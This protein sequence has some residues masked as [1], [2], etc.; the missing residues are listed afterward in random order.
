[1]CETCYNCKKCNWTN[2]YMYCK[3]HR[4]QHMVDDAMYWVLDMFGR[5]IHRSKNGK[6]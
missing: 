5:L 4:L 6:D 3:K 2:D 1:M